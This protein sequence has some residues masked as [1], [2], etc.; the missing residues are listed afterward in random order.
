MPLGPL[1]DEAARHWPFT[2]RTVELLWPLWC[3]K[4]A[5]ST[6]PM[7]AKV[8][9]SHVVSPKVIINQGGQKSEMH[10]R[11][12]RVTVDELDLSAQLCCLWVSV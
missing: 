9:E 12:R 3:L 8:R 7:S 2:Q 1:A 11:Q 10:G 5:T 6:P 4:L